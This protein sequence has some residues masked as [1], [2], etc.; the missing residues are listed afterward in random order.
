MFNNSFSKTIL[1]D[2]WPTDRAVSNR[3]HWHLYE[4]RRLQRR[5]RVRRRQKQ[6]PLRDSVYE[7]QAQRLIGCTA[8][9]VNGTVASCSVGVGTWCFVYYELATLIR[10]SVNCNSRLRAIVLLLPPGGNC[11]ANNFFID[12]D[13]SRSNVQR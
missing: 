12:I 9:D 5:L 3:L 11:R 4:S 1:T 2:V 13:E 7:F 6:Q 8:S 10:R